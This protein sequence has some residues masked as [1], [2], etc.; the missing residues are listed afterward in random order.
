M[1][2]KWF[3][4]G[5]C[6][7]SVLVTLASVYGAIWLGIDAHRLYP[8]VQNMSGQVTWDSIWIVWDY[9]KDTVGCILF[10]WATWKNGKTLRNV[11]KEF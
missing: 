5:L 9:V 10:A 2:D 4:R 1:S 8:R 3:L 6:A 7:M 11:I